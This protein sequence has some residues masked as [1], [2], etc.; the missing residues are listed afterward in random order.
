MPWRKDSYPLQYSGLENSMDCIV[1]GVS[2]SQSRTSD[3]HFLAYGTEQL[4]TF[5]VLTLS[6]HLRLFSGLPLKPSPGTGA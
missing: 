6:L 2:E 3:F 5:W 4:V 1:L